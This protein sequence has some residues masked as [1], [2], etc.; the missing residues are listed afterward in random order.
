MSEVIYLNAD[1]TSRALRTQ[2]G[3]TAPTFGPQ[4]YIREAYAGMWIVHDESD[5]K[6][7]CFRDHEAALRFAQ[8]EFGTGV[9]IVVQPQFSGASRRSLSHFK[10]ATAVAHKALAAH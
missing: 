9:G 3:E 5:T 8:E 6:G 10:Q 4:V 7:G 1:R 2:P